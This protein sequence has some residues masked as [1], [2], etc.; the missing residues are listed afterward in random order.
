MYIYAYTHILYD[1]DWKMQM[2]FITNFQ[3][4]V[5][6]VQGRDTLEEIT[7][8]LAQIARGSNLEDPGRSSRDRTS[9]M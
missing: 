6:T 5:K 9:R 4:Y 1:E 7:P 2:I 8:R 3:I